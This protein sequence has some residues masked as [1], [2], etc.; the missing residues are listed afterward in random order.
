M[1][2]IST[3]AITALLLLCAVAKGQDTAQQKFQTA[4][5]EEAARVAKSSSAADRVAFA[6]R[7]VEGARHESDHPL[8]ILLC[9]KAV[10]LASA[11]LVGFSTAR[12][13]TELWATLAPD[14][15]AQ[16]RQKMADLCRGTYEKAPGADKKSAAACLVDLFL[17]MALADLGRGDPGPAVKSLQ[18]A[19]RIAHIDAAQWEAILGESLALAQARAAADA[20]LA[21]LQ[22][23]LA[24]DAKNAAFAQQAALVCLLELD[25]P[26]KALEFKDAA[27][28]EEAFQ[29]NL[30]LARQ[31]VNALDEKTCASLRD[32]YRGLAAKANGWGRVTALSRAM[33]F[34]RRCLD[35]HKDPNAIPAAAT[36]AMDEITKDLW[37]TTEKLNGGWIDLLA[38]ADC[39]RHAVGGCKWERDP[40]GVHCRPNNSGPLVVPYQPPEEYDL[41]LVFTA[42]GG[43]AQ[44]LFTRYKGIQFYCQAAT[45]PDFSGMWMFGNN[46]PRP[47]SL[48]RETPLVRG[49]KYSILVQ[50]RKQSICMLLDADTV[51]NYKGK[52]RIGL[53]TWRTLPPAS[54]AGIYAADDTAVFHLFRVHEITG[55]GKFMSLDDLKN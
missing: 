54:V 39:R 28:L 22:K 46:S 52:E 38:A 34:G 27:G 9:Q 21:G 4:F 45:L 47:N 42:G 50:V 32:W 49:R 53:P 5:G 1:R 20:R 13:A 2:R 31:H 17:G 8:A 23:S 29:Q 16:C 26:A 12:E 14:Q 37:V 10:E 25:R 18:D 7:L 41:Q 15:K 35:L 36:G 11:T 19:Q 55:K 40:S 24:G 6:A 43:K 48:G 33:C 3:L 44:G 30:E 51:L